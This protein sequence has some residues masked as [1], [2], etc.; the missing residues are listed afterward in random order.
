MPNSEGA[1]YA[2]EQLSLLEY[3]AMSLDWTMDPAA[4][5]K[6]TKQKVTLQGN[7]D[8][9]LLYGDDEIIQSQVRKMLGAFGPKQH[10][11]NLGHGMQ[12]DHEPKKLRV[13]LEAI[14]SIS[15][16]LNK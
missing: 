9:G 14:K 12:P 15:T 5:R 7:A 13:Y 10:I 6:I 11:A 16:E 3:D 4:V 1:H 2:V 8:P